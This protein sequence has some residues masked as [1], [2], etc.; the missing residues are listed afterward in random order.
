M[1][2]KLPEFLCPAECVDTQDF[3]GLDSY[4]GI[5]TLELHRMHQL[6]DASLSNF[7]GAPRFSHHGRGSKIDVAKKL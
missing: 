5:S 2:G 7:S 4:W 1:A 6:V 3:V